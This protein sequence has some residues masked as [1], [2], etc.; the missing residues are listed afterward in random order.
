MSEWC[1]RQIEVQGGELVFDSTLT[2][3]GQCAVELVAL[4]PVDT[5][6]SVYFSFFNVSGLCRANV[7]IKEPGATPMQSGSYDKRGR[8]RYYFVLHPFKI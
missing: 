2:R 3:G 7:T 6:W 5:M 4:G 8:C 1:G